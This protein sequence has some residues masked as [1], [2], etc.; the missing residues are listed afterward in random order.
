MKKQ[1]AFN[2]ITPLVGID[3]EE[4]ETIINYSYKD[5]S[6]S[7]YTTDNTVINKMKKIMMKGNDYVCFADIESDGKINSYEFIFP[8]KFVSLRVGSNHKKRELTDEQRKAIGERLKSA[9]K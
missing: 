5:V 4:K 2:E 7:L 6:A 9:R 8:K 3:V 1:I